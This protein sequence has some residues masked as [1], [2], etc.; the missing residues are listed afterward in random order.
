MTTAA[1]RVEAARVRRR[2]TKADLARRA[3]VP[4]NWVRSFCTGKIGK[5]DPERLRR[6]A[7]VLGIDHRELL[8]LT[9]QL[10]AAE[11]VEARAASAA[12][13]S[14]LVRVLERQA[15]AIE[16]QTAAVGELVSV[17]RQDR[18]AISPE[19]FQLF[20]AQLRSEGLLVEPSGLDTIPTPDGRP[21]ARGS[22]G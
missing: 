2:M 20:L 13:L 22:A 8:A 5:A 16:A 14:D 6:M 10:G 7:G 9:D 1:E 15:A 12:G 17:L 4:A 21:G 18:D 19:G 3:G 11:E